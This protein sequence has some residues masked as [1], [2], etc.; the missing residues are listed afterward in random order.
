[1]GDVG[2]RPSSTSRTS[3]KMHARIHHAAVVIVVMLLAGCKAPP[4]M[5]TVADVVRDH[6]PHYQQVLDNVAKFNQEPDA[7]PTHVMVYKGYFESRRTWTGAI[8]TT[9][10]LEDSTY[11]QTHWDLAALEDPYDIRR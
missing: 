10:K 3:V 4:S 9:T 8:G 2:Q 1:M 7:W 5:M 11:A 6:K